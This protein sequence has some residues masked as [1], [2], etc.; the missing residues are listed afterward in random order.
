MNR[1]TNS[2]R[3]VRRESSEDVEKALLPKENIGEVRHER[4]ICGLPVMVIVKLSAWQLV[5]TLRSFRIAR[6]I[7]V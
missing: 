1:T 5:N 3:S 7:Y 2:P 6:D 4:L